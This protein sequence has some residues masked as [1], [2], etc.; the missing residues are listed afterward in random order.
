MRAVMLAALCL[1]SLAFVPVADAQPDPPQCIWAGPSVT[2][3]PV[4]VSS[5]C[6]EGPSVSYDPA[7]CTE[8]ELC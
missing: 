3:G 2:V 8:K 1:A 4:T 6:G 7:W 5:Y